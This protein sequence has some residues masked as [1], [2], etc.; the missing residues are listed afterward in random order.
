MKVIK[1][2]KDNKDDLYTETSDDLFSKEYENVCKRTLDLEKP[3]L[4]NLPL[5]NRNLIIKSNEHNMAIFQ[6]GILYVLQDKIFVWKC[7]LRFWNTFHRKELFRY[8]QMAFNKICC[9]CHN[10]IFSDSFFLTSLGEL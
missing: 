1:I 8:R 2:D 10:R 3:R 9:Y 7:N 4:S 6:G 5:S